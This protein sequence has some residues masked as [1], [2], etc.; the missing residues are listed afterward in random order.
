MAF[1]TLNLGWRHKINDRIAVTATAQDVLNSTRY[2][3][4]L[5][6]A[7]LRETFEIRPVTRALIVRLDYRFGGGGKAARDPGF[8]YETGGPPTP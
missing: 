2:G 1:S 6:T 7:A 8:E 4:T 5:D 3:Y